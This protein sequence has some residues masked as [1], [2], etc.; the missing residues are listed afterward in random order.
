MT[1]KIELQFIAKEALEKE[2]ENVAFRSFLKNLDMRSRDLDA[3]VHEIYDEVSAQIDCTQCANCC[4]VTRPVLTQQDVTRFAN[5]LAIAPPIF[6]ETH[7]IPHDERPGK[8]KFNAQPC[9]FLADD[10][11]TNYAA[12]PHVCSS[13]PHLHKK[14]FRS[15]LWNVV[16]NYEL[17]PIVYHVYEQLKRELWQDDEFL[18]DDDFLDDDFLGYLEW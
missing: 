18:E 10:L 15:R 16:F 14:D 5:G 2:D 1:L 4:K 6:L 12:R 8:F 17:C 11:C 9:P 3:I 7:L 13:F